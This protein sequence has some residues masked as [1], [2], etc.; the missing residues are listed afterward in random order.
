MVECGCS[1]GKG[2]SFEDDRT[3]AGQGGFG[4]RM[5]LVAAGKGVSLYTF[6]MD[7][8]DC[9]QE[10][11]MGHQ[12]PVV[13]FKFVSDHRDDAWWPIDVEVFGAV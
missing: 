13:T 1:H 6:V 12:I 10:F 11:I 2:W 8:M 3:L 9:N 7:L 4:F 5:K